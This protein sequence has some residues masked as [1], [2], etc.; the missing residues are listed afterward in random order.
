MGAQI[1]FSI[2]I[3]V[4]LIFRREHNIVN[5][6]NDKWNFETS[7]KCRW[8]LAVNRWPGSLDLINFRLSIDRKL[9][10]INSYMVINNS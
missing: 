3:K 1:I 8:P 9:V 10:I 4:C 6:R 5:F 7:L 2:G